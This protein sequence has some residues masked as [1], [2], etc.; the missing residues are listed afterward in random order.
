[1]LHMESV[2][3]RELRQNASAILRRVEAGE[4]FE[5]TD[6]GRPVG[7]LVPPAPTGLDALVR[8]GLIRRGEGDLLDVEPLAPRPGDPLPSELV[9][10]GRDE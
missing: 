1:M 6:R 4:S 8:R 7:L 9:S 5:V 3:I 10:E 2:G